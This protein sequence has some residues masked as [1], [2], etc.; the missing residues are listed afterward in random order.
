M[1]LPTEWYFPA[2]VEDN[3][4]TLGNT[5]KN[6][7]TGSNSNDF[8]ESLKTMY[9]QV[10][11]AV[12]GQQK[13][14]TDPVSYRWLPTLAGTGTA[15]TFTYTSQVGFAQRTGIMTECWF[16]ITWTVQVG[17]VGNLYVQLPYQVTQAS[18][19][20]FCGVIQVSDLAFPAG[21]TY[22]TCTAVP[23]TYQLQIWA[24]G[25]ATTSVNVPVAASGRVMGYVRY[26]GVQES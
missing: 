8:L 26:I 18:G 14:S 17:A 15:G 6:T 21:T 2:A 4:V 20:P 5:A 16:D 19:I 1:T 22:L 24:S 12:N 7:A 3:T 11:L 23:S 9:S 10:A 13:R 25:D